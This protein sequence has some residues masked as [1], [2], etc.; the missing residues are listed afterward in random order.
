MDLLLYNQI[1]IENLFNDYKWND[2]TLN[3]IKDNN[4]IN[5][6]KYY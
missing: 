2:H 5:K 1:K 4:L 6:L 3:G